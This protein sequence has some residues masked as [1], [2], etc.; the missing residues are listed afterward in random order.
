MTEGLLECLRDD[1]AVWL[2]RGA[3]LAEV[4]GQLIESAPALSE[5][6]RA[7]LWLFAWSYAASGRRGAPRQ[8]GLVAR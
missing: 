6:E 2:D 3:A 1:V 7:G 4:Q 5:D 8:P